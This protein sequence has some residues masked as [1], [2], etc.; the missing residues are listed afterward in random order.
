MGHP[1]QFPHLSAP[2]VAIFKQ[3]AHRIPE[4]ETKAFT[5]Q[6]KLTSALHRIHKIEPREVTLK[7]CRHTGPEGAEGPALTQPPCH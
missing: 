4:N 1:H 6:Y 5:R 7:E 2:T 3:L